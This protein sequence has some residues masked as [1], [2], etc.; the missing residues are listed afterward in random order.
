M[1][2]SAIVVGLCFVLTMLVMLGVAKKNRCS[3]QKIRAKV[4]GYEILYRSSSDS[5]EYH[6]ILDYVYDNKKYRVV[7]NTAGQSPK[8]KL[9]EEISISCNE[10]NP[11]DFIEIVPVRGLVIRAL[12][13]GSLGMLIVILGIV[14]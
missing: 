1:S 9:G 12:V 11:E 5:K 13:M 2:V 8:Y 6:Y 4:V 10:N 14:I 3:E 7:S